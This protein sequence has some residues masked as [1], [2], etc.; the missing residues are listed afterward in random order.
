MERDQEL[1]LQAL[2][3]GQL[4]N[5]EARRL[6]RWLTSDQEAAALLEELRWTKNVLTANPPQMVVPESREFYW[7]K[8]QRAIL[9]VE[10]DRA[11]KPDFRLSPFL[12]WKKWL[13]PI[14]GLALFL[15]VAWGTFNIVNLDANRLHARVLAQVES[16]SEEMSAFSFRSQSQNVFVVWLYERTTETRP[17]VSLVNDM[18]IQ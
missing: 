17:E 4:S 16:P 15:L 8:I 13:T 12:Q 5:R 6:E 9:R 3:D 10:P 14:S 11:A 18:I 2:V 1:K 7:S